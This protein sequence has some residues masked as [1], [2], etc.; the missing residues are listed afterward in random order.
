MPVKDT[1]KI[2][3]EEGFAIQTPN[4][5]TVWAVQT[6][7]VFEKDLIVKAYGSLVEGLEELQAKFVLKKVAMKTLDTAI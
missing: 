3:D 7:Q 6:P 5:K 1:V 2:S 4:R